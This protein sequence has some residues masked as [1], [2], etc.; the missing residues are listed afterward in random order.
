MAK[1]MTIPQMLESI[2]MGGVITVY[3]PMLKVL[4]AVGRINSRRSGVWYDVSVI[5]DNGL[6]LVIIAKR[7]A[8]DVASEEHILN[9]QR[10]FKKYG[11]QS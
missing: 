8:W 7:E 6:N 11:W 1:Q 9:S 2:P 3:A 10:F 5:A 4:E